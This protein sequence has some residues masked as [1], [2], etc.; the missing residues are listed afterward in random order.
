MEVMVS[1]LKDFIIYYDE[2]LTNEIYNT[3]INSYSQKAAIKEFIL[4]I[5]MMFILLED[6]RLMKKISLRV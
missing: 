4:K 3:N 5:K 2:S 1:G 6:K